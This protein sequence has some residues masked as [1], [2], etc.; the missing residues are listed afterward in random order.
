MSRLLILLIP[1]L[2]SLPAFAQDWPSKTWSQALA[3]ASPAIAALE[4]YAFTERDDVA[5]QGVRTDALLV[6]QDGRIVYERYAGPGAADRVHATWSISKS[7]LATVLGVAYGEGRFELQDAA[8]DYFQPL[9]QHRDIRVQDLLH[10][11]SGLDWQED[12]EYAPLDSSVVAMLYTR[13]HRDMASYA[14]SHRRAEAPGERFR[15]SSGDSNLLAAALRNMVGIHDYPD[16]PWYALFT[17]LGIDQA[18]W[19]TD[20]SGTFVASSYAY[21]TA[22]DLARVGLLMQRDGQWHG[23]N[24][25]HPR[26]SRSTAPPLLPARTYRASLPQ[27]ATGGSTA[28]LP[29]PMHRAARWQRWG[30]GDRPCTCCPSS[31]WWSCAM[32]MI[33]TPASAMTRYC[34][35]YLPPLPRQVAN[36]HRQTRLGGVGLVALAG[37]RYLVVARAHAA[38]GIPR[39]TERLLG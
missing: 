34:S 3:P 9:A 33:A 7:L 22:R 38:V 13:G 17:P 26:G 4:Q 19:E 23:S 29:G 10:W 28:M 1:L 15:Y 39:H 21:L 27:A 5:R 35:G 16:Y 8:A 2:C 25:C 36:E 18:V 12:Y 31:A 30:T 37:G 6:I 14:A 32:P 24:C 11:A 20:A